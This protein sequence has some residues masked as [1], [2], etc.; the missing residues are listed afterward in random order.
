MSQKCWKCTL[1]CILSPHM[2]KDTKDYKYYT[3]SI[4]LLEQAILAAAAAL[5]LHS[6]EKPGCRQMQIHLFGNQ[7]DDYDD[8]DSS[9]WVTWLE[10]L[11]G[12][13]EQLK[14][15]EKPSAALSR[16]SQKS[17]PEGALHFQLHKWKSY[18]L[19]HLFQSPKNV[20]IRTD[21]MGVIVII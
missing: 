12:G 21:W 8:A 5:L 6:T 3:V 19:E 1:F 17:G 9:V 14:R 2:T 18:D 13:M 16:L 20:N 15:P 11:K 10:R 7:Y 4:N